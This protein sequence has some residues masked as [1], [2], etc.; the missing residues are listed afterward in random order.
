MVDPLFLLKDWFLV[1]RPFCEKSFF[2]PYCY[3]QFTVMFCALFEASSGKITIARVYRVG[4]T[5][6]NLFVY[7]TP[8]WLYSW[9]SIV[10]LL[11]FFAQGASIF[12]QKSHS[13]PIEEQHSYFRLHEELHL[14]PKYG[15]QIV[16]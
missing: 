13:N 14:R 16:I 10:P 5:C 12:D 11:T 8:E 15:L 6:K 9:R 3:G 4:K 7:Y 1:R 2:F